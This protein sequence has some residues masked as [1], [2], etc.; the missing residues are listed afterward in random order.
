MEHVIQNDL[1]E[2][3]EEGITAEEV[4]HAYDIINR[5]KSRKNSMSWN[6]PQELLLDAW[7]ENAASYKWMHIKAARYYNFLNDLITIPIIVLSS[8]SAMGAVFV[9]SNHEGET[10][11]QVNNIIEYIF[12]GANLIVATLSSIQKYKRFGEN[13]DRHRTAAV[14]YSKFYREIKLELVLDPKARNFATDYS[15]NIKMAYDKLLSNS[16][17]IPQHISKGFEK[18]KDQPYCKT[19]IQTN[20]SIPFCL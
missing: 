15:K 5:E 9:I 6:K 13:S 2:E 11:D 17:E 4:Y 18:I 16:P 3:P 10:T 20:A 14:E 12:A 1:F 7:A 19:F 8:L